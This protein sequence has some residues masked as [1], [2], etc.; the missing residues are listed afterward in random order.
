MPILRPRI[1]LITALLGIGFALGILVSMNGSADTRAL[2]NLSADEGR[3]LVALAQDFFP[4][5]EEARYRECIVPVDAAM[6]DPAQKAQMQ[7]ALSLVLGGARRMGYSS[8]PEITD[9]YERQ[10]LAKMIAEGQWMRGFR[11]DLGRCLEGEKKV[12]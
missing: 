9:D 1:P 5:E 2:R 3:T 10:R 11:S 6:A 4:D 7:D 8:Y 12:R